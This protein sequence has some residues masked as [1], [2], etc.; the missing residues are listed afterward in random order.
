MDFDNEALADNEEP[1]DELRLP[2]HLAALVGA[3]LQGPADLAVHR[4]RYPTSPHQEEP[5]GAITA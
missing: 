5:G 1:L 4:D 3:P 2:R